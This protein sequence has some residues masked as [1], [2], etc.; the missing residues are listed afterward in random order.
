MSQ[1][2]PA[3]CQILS[4]SYEALHQRRAA[5]H[6]RGVTLELG[7]AMFRP[8]FLTYSKIAGTVRSRIGPQ[9]QKQKPGSKGEGER[10]AR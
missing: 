10:R 7:S 1:P 5:P 2:V 8:S 3:P 4:I 6:C 9:R